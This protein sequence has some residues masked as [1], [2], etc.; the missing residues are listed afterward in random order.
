M[1]TWRDTT[2]GDFC[3]FSYGK[4]LPE[5][6]RRSGKFPILSSAGIVG[7]HDEP[8]VNGSGV[9]IGRKGT[10]GSVTYVDSPFWP[11]DTAFY[12][13]DSLRM[14][15]LRFTYYLLKSLPLRDMNSD[16]A[17]PGLNRDNAHL[18]DIRVPDLDTQE[19]IG[20]VLGALD[21][22][23]ELNRRINQT[24]EAIAHQRRDGKEV[25]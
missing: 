13:S 14:R 9:V 12:V 18:L 19:S 23:I 7:A 5:R 17:V 22:K 11:I 3:P 21:D 4:A 6:A 20:R 24:L 2:S 1:S 10:V 15:D 25:W 16:S 8:L